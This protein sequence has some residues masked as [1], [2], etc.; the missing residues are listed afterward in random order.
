MEYGRDELIRQRAHEIWE[1]E[2]RPHG[3]EREHWDRAEREV[4]Q[5]AEGITGKSPFAADQ[6]QSIPPLA[7]VP[8][9]KKKRA[10]AKTAT[11]KTAT[12]KT[13]AAKAGT[14]AKTGTAKK[15]P[16]KKKA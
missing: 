5:G 7:E 10:P 9:V 6:E 12:A 14:A 13:G 2:G 11:A 1:Q 16:A 4:A 8:I 3:K 15:A